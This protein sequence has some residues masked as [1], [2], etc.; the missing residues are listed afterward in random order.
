M[1][2]NN[3]QASYDSVASDYAKQFHDEM[4]KK[5]FDCHMLKWLAE[6]VGDG[7]TICDLGCGPGQIA[8]YLHQQGVTVC[9]IDLSQEM[10]VQAKQS[11][12][13]IPFQQGDMLGLTDVADAS[14][15]GIAAFYAIIHIPPAQV[16]QALSEIRRVL[17]DG[18]TLLVTFHIGDEVRHLDEWWN[19]Q[20]NLDFIFFYTHQMKTYLQEAGFTITEAIERD[21][22]PEI[23][24]QTRRAYLFAVKK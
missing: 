3:T 23:E 11:Y 6:R 9:G 5:P 22:Y 16:P 20:V 1:T 24:V 17:R 8:D 12:P 4:S 14:F 19:H 15:A 10:V 13:H 21:P 2:T 18:G 7:G